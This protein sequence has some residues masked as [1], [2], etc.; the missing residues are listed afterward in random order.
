MYLTNLVSHFF[1]HIFLVPLEVRVFSEI[2]GDISLRKVT[3][4][5][6]RFKVPVKGERGLTQAGRSG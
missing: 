1:I 2:L 6:C 4:S 5:I 3:V